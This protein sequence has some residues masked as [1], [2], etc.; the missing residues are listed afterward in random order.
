MSGDWDAE[1][2]NDR[3]SPELDTETRGVVLDLTR[4]VV[5]VPEPPTEPAQ[6]ITSA[7]QADVGPPEE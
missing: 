2:W 5:A 3:L 1:T 6:P 4:P 7:L